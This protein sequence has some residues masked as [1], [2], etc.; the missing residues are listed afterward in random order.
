M[1]TLRPGSHVYRLMLV[2]AAVGEFPSRSLR[3][4]RAGL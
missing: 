1:L 4:H 3:L 2:L